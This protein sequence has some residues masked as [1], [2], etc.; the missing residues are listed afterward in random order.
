MRK[1][2]IAQ[3]LEVDESEVHDLC[4]ELLEVD[5][6]VHEKVEVHHVEYL[7]HLSLLQG[8][9]A[10]VGHVVGQVSDLYAP[11]RVHKHAQAFQ[12]LV[13][14]TSVFK[15]LAV[16]NLLKTFLKH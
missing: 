14:N 15:P 11:F 4:D 10:Q 3:V 12:Y 1:G 7:L 8:T 13:Q 16:F 5:P 9:L 2:Q 6:A